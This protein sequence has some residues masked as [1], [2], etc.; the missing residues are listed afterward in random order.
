MDGA[1]GIKAVDELRGMPS[2]PPGT[3]AAAYER[4]DM[5]PG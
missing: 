5:S 1:Q 4:A 2:V 3:D